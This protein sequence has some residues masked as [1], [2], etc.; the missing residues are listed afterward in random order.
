MI[1]I[2]INSFLKKYNPGE[3]EFMWGVREHGYIVDD[4]TDDPG[5]WSRDIDFLI[6]PVFGEDAVTAIEV[7]WDKRIAATGNL[8]I[9]LENPRSRS[10]HGW[11]E[12]CEADYL[13]YGDARNRI[14]YF[15][16]LTDLRD[17][18][19]EH[20]LE[21]KYMTTADGSYGYLLPLLHV[22]H[23]VQGTMKI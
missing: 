9:E 16:K 17:Y 23:I 19:K 21:M 12:F 11:F 15:I 4:V 22:K 5:Y 13:A 10:G 3:K 2:D 8:F 20:K 7:K 6:T 1:D 18:I 14:F